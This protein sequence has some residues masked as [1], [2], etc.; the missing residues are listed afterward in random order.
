[1]ASSFLWF[2]Y[3]NVQS[4]P[5]LLV[6]SSLNQSKPSLQHCRRSKTLSSCSYFWLHSPA[7]HVNFITII[8][9][10]ISLLIL[11]KTWFYVPFCLCLKQG[12]IKLIF[13]VFCV[14]LATN[15][16]QHKTFRMN[17]QS[18]TQII[19]THTFTDL[20]KRQYKNTA[21]LSLVQKQ[22]MA[23]SFPFNTNKVTSSK[24]GM[25]YTTLTIKKKVLENLY[26]NPPLLS[27]SCFPCHWKLEI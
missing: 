17:L 16:G 21:I 15:Q 24:M 1:M 7:L 20:A 4:R 26:K 19:M 14:T 9:N 12:K 23:K 25:I 27:T 13:P 5:I 11:F 3:R 8:T 6:L 22:A 10:T 2:C 18:S